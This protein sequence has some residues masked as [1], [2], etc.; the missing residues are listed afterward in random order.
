MNPC[1]SSHQKH[2]PLCTKC[3]P[4][5]TLKSQENTGVTSCNTTIKPKTTEKSLDTERTPSSR[6]KHHSLGEKKKKQVL[7]SI[8]S[9]PLPVS[10]SASARALDC[11]IRTNNTKK[12]PN[13]T[14][15]LTRNP[16]EQHTSHHQLSF[17]TTAAGAR[18]Y[19]TNQVSCMLCS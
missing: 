18:S 17:E 19:E 5:L 11:R 14:C 1:K 16:A 8:V 15:K 9:V 2:L 13:K 12:K 10:A 3:C 7:Q 4:V 6:L